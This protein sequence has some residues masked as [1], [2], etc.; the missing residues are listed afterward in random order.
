MRSNWL[1]YLG[2]GIDIFAFVVAISSS[3]LM[4]SPVHSSDGTVY[5]TSDGLSAYG[6]MMAWLIPLGLLA[7]VG[8]GFWLRSIGKNLIANVLVWIPALPMFAGILIWGGLAALFILFG[9]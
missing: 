2:V 8:C 4:D 3:F 1:F 5:D 6:K 7:I 9:K